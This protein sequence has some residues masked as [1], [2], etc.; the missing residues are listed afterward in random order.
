MSAGPPIEFPRFIYIYTEL[1]HSKIHGLPHVS[2]NIMMDIQKVYRR[3]RVL[4]VHCWLENWPLENQVPNSRCEVPM[5]L[6]PGFG[7]V[8]RL[9][10]R[11]GCCELRRATINASV[12]AGLVMNVFF[13]YLILSLVADRARAAPNPPTRALTDLR[14]ALR[15]G[16]SAQ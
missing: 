13:N 11:W 6:T 5:R 10:W 3:Q 15:S 1:H 8:R 12:P 9:K 2:S 4:H 16:G 14:C 7:I